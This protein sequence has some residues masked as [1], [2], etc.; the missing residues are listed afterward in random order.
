MRQIMKILGIRNSFGKAFSELVNNPRWSVGPNNCSILLFDESEPSSIND[1]SQSSA[2]FQ[3]EFNYDLLKRCVGMLPALFSY[4]NVTNKFTIDNPANISEQ[5]STAGRKIDQYAPPDISCL[6]V[7]TLST[8][9]MVNPTNT[10]IS[11]NTIW[12]APALI[13]QKPFSGSV[14]TPDKSSYTLGTQLE[15]IPRFQAIPR[16]GS[17]RT[18][19][20]ALSMVY[21]TSPGTPGFNRGCI[22]EFNEVKTINKLLMRVQQVVLTSWMQVRIHYRNSEGD[23]VLATEFRVVLGSVAG[24]F[25]MTGSYVEFNIPEFNSDLVHVACMYVGGSVTSGNPGDVRLSEIAFGRSDQSST[26]QP[27]NA[28]FGI[29]AFGQRDYT[30]RLSDEFGKFKQTHVPMI[31]LPVGNAINQINVNLNDGPNYLHLTQPIELGME[32]LS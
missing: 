9:T 32:D 3:S 30:D 7:P 15:E 16:F 10:T 12:Y 25:N 18:P 1:L 27:L 21:M 4:N 5:V 28:V 29:V 11:V 22:V 6:L 19:G 31:K 17:N 20:W 13:T 24:N 8:T 23:F 14:A 26:I 2:G